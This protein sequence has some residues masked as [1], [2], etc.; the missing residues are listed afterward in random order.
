MYKYRCFRCRRSLLTPSLRTPWTPAPSQTALAETPA[1]RNAVLACPNAPVADGLGGALSDKSMS[2]LSPPRPRQQRPVR[3][4]LAVNSGIDF[5]VCCP[6]LYNTVL[7][8]SA[9]RWRLLWPLSHACTVVST[10]KVSRAFLSTEQNPDYYTAVLTNMRT[11]RSCAGAVNL[12]GLV[13]SMRCTQRF[14][15]PQPIFKCLDV[16]V[17]LF[18]SW[19][20]RRHL[21]SHNNAFNAFDTYFM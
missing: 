6:N 5:D 7:L 17:S 12:V 1:T 11:G 15:R 4:A 16:S 19:L 14:P 3:M 10:H 20:P 8:Q 2:C 13:A 21:Q 9:T 18:D